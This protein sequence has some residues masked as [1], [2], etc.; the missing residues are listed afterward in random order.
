MNSR[1]STRAWRK[2]RAR[3]IREEPTCRLRLTGCTRTSTTADHI[4]PRSKRPDL[5]MVRSNLRGACAHCNYSRGNRTNPLRA[6]AADNPA[7]RFFDTTTG[8][9]G[10]LS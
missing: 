8:H 1:G 5:T 6:K 4:I 9:P 2:L 7:L 10:A 3:V